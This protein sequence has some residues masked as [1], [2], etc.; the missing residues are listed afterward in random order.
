MTKPDMDSTP[1]RQ[2]LAWFNKQMGDLHTANRGAR[3][4][5]DLLAADNADLMED[6][7]AIK[8]T[9][10][11][12]HAKVDSDAAAIGELKARVDK[13]AEWAKTLNKKNGE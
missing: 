6:I 7:E 11:T 1:D 9:C 13:M 4:K 5:N 10:E 12:L 8:A 3:H 2:T